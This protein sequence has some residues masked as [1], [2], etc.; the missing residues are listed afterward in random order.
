MYYGILR[1]SQSCYFV[2]R[3]IANGSIRT[4]KKEEEKNFTTYKGIQMGS[5]AKSSMRKGFLIRKCAKFLPDMR[6]E[7]VFS[8][9]YI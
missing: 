4:D 5:A 8:L 7:E 2:V 9:I 1:L 3:F 6:I